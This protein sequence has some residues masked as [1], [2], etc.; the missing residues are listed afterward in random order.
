[1]YEIIYQRD[2]LG[3]LVFL[4]TNGDFDKLMENEPG[5][6]VMAVAALHLRDFYKFDRILDLKQRVLSQK[7]EYLPQIAN[8]QQ[9]RLHL[10]NIVGLN[11]NLIN[12]QQVIQQ[13]EHVYDD[14]RQ[15]LC[16][17]SQDAKLNA[18]K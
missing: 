9:K 4:A 3:S 15:V 5:I 16:E 12:L 6:G 1:M 18:L 7:F 17:I 2:I 11:E 14:V 13:C 10:F 8:S